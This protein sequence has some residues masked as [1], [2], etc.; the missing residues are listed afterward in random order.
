[1]PAI[2]VSRLVAR[3]FLDPSDTALRDARDQAARGDL[4]QA[5]LI[6]QRAIG[7]VL[8]CGL[9]V[10]AHATHDGQ[11]PDAVSI[12][13]HGVWLERS[14]VPHVEAQISEIAGKDAD[15][16]ASRLRALGHQVASSEIA[17]MYVHVELDEALHAALSADPVPQG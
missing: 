5:W 16:L 15:R 13:N 11:R 6:D 1:M 12:V 4:D 17:R 9:E 10:T 3:A 14:G 7:A 2:T 8:L